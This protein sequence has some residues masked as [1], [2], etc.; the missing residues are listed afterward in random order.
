MLLMCSALMSIN[1]FL[2]AHGLG[3]Y[4]HGVRVYVCVD[5]YILPKQNKMSEIEKEN[6][7][8]HC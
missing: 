3:V 5:R 1:A 2:Q 6:R 8:T 7:F 4:V